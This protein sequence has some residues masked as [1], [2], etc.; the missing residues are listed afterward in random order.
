MQI[1]RASTCSLKFSNPGKKE[2]L[3]CVLEEYGRVVN[4][5]IGQFWE[6][7]PAKG[8]LLKPV[9]DSVDTWFS[10]RLRKVAAREAI[11]MVKANRNRDGEKAVKPTHRGQR[12]CVSSTIADLQI[13]NKSR[14]FDAWLRITSIGNG[15]KLNIPIKRH[16][17]FN[18]LAIRGK[19]LNSYVITRD[20]VQFCFAIETG[21]KKPKTACRGVDTGINA[22]ASTSDNRQFGSDI[23]KHI[24]R[25]IRCQRGSK[26]HKRAVRALRQRMDEVAKE[27][28]DDA[29]LVV[30]ENLKNITKNT[31]K[32]R[33]L[34]RKTRRLIGRWN[35]RY[36]L[37]RLEMT[38]QDRNVSFRTVSS[39]YTS[40]TCSECGYV[41]QK[42]RNGELFRCLSCG[43]EA[44]ADVQ[45]SR[46][47]LSRFLSGPYGAGCK[48]MSCLTT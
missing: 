24:D 23:R 12:M 25:V 37:T 11:D 22:L 28:T 44:N 30:V 17:H 34:G 48:P 41:D 33:R 42:N 3:S 27:V 5:F 38:C 4:C 43:H 7:C 32:R 1:N 21:P 31:K 2:Q 10:A 6:D 36:W 35:V 46:N 47:I 45:A 40:Q 18:D 15:I 13:S 20:S 16:K 29:T 8:K 19:R 9:V 14:E 39:W 26:G